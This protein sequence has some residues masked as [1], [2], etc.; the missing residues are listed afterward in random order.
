MFIFLIDKRMKLVKYT[1]PRQEI[2]A[3][4]SQFSGR[5]AAEYET[6]SGFV[7]VIDALDGVEE[8]RGNLDFVDEYGEGVSF[9]GRLRQILMS[10]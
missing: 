6:E 9:L 10:S 3:R 1:A 8:F 2:G 7:I 5:A 4:G